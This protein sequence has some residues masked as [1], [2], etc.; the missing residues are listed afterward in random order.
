MFARVAV[1]EIPGHRMDEAVEGFREA[2][3]QIAEKHPEEVLLLVSRESN[4]ALTMSLWERHDAMEGS[5]MMATR[6]RT[7]AAKSVGGSIQSVVEYEIAVRETI[8][9]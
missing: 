4:R 6:L 1:Y 3:S 8:G 5:R 7:E 2:I 9:S